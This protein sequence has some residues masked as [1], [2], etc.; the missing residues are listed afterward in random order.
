M[1]LLYPD[2]TEHRE[3]TERGLDGGAVDKLLVGLGED[4]Q[5]NL[6]RPLFSKTSSLA[7]FSLNFLLTTNKTIS[8]HL[9]SNHAVQNVYRY[10]LVLHL[11]Y[12]S[13]ILSAIP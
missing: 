1:H 4:N 5:L 8:I 12:I 3:Q 10:F 7:V 13:D 11:E 2:S 6:Y 9:C